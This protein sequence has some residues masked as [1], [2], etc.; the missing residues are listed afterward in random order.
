[1]RLNIE[2][3]NEALLE[4]KQSEVLAVITGEK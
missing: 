3:D 1:V 4:A 2:A